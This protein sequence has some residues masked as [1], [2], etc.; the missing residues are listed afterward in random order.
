MRVKLTDPLCDLQQFV[1]D[2]AACGIV[3]SL[4]LQAHSQYFFDTDSDQAEVCM[5]YSQQ[6]RVAEDHQD[7]CRARRSS[8]KAGNDTSPRLVVYML[9]PMSFPF[10]AGVSGGN[11][12]STKLRRGDAVRLWREFLTR[13][14]P[15]SIINHACVY[16]YTATDVAELS[17]GFKCYASIRRRTLRRLRRQNDDYPPNSRFSLSC[18]IHAYYQSSIS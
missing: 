18:T 14:L 11:P 15:D 10:G 2:L 5:D 8:D 7:C 6:P 16:I 1:Q 4:L 17:R 13:R 12:M 3:F 9:I